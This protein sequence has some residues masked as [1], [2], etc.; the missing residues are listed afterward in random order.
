V[1]SE[2]SS[3]RLCSWNTFKGFLYIDKDGD[4][5]T[6]S[7]AAYDLIATWKIFGTVYMVPIHLIKALLQ[8]QTLPEYIKKPCLSWKLHFCE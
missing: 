6:A 1:V 8:K 3:S 2:V 4:L 7:H 5:T